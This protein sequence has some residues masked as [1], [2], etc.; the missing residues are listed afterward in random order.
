VVL[1]RHV[2]EM[3]VAETVASL[4][5]SEVVVKAH[6]HRAHAMLRK[7][8]YLQAQGRTTDLYQFHAVHCGRVV[9]AVFDS[10][11][12]NQGASATPWMI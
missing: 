9:K 3:S 11:R 6:L 7:E 1:M 8:I 10:I 4:G 5:V 2:E 12:V